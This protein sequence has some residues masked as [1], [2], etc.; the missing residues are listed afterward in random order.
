[1]GGGG[2]SVFFQSNLQLSEIT[3]E[4]QHM[5]PKGGGGVKLFFQGDGVQLFSIEL[6]ICT[7]PV[8]PL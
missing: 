2:S 5:L 3:G 6:I 8:S 7:G 1:M 4:V